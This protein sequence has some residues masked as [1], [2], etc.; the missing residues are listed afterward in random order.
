MKNTEDNKIRVE[1]KEQARKERQEKSPDRLDTVVHLCMNMEPMP[2]VNRQVNHAPR[3]GVPA[4]YWKQ[5]EDL[6]DSV[7]DSVFGGGWG[8]I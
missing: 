5:L 1:P 3:C 2:T 8:G 7:P 4:E 6:D